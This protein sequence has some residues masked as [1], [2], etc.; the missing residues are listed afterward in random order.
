[1]FEKILRKIMKNHQIFENKADFKVQLGMH[2]KMLKNWGQKV[3]GK[4]PV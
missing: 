3:S 2:L 1:M 4:L